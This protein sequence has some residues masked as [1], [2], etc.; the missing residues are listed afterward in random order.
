MSKIYRRP[1]FRGGGKVSSYG[2]GITAPLVPGYQ[3]GGQIGGGQIYGTPMGDGRYGFAQPVTLSEKLKAD[4]LTNGV[5][6]STENL[7]LGSDLLNNNRF[8]KT[9]APQKVNIEEDISTSTDNDASSKNIDG[10]EGETYTESIAKEQDKIFG[11]GNF[12]SFDQTEER[13]IIDENGNK[14][15]VQANV[16]AS[17]VEPNLDVLKNLPLWAGGIT[18]E[19]YKIRKNK[20]EI[21]KIQKRV[22]ADQ[23]NIARAGGAD[24]AQDDF[25]A[26]FASKEIGDGVGDKS[27]VVN[28]PEETQISAKDAIRENQELFKE[29]LGGKAARGQDISDMLLR[30]SGSQG[31]TLGEKFKNYTKAES[32]AG[33][34]RG[35]KINQTAAALAINDY[36]AGKRSDEQ[37]EYLTKKI[38]YEYKKKGELSTLNIDDDIGTAL[39]KSAKLTDSSFKSLKNIKNIINKKT[40]RDDIY[41]GNIK[42]KD[43][44]PKSFKQ[45]KVNKLKPGY[46]IVEDE[47]VKRIVLIGN[48]GTNNTVI[49]IQTI[50]ELWTGK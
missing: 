36:V 17:E 19:E 50:T 37:S 44:D 43:L 14:K 9:V 2:N 18:K 38:D 48:D 29:L 7:V 28:Q 10:G 25:D 34:G 33:P 26:G 15:I 49:S 47:G 13:T 24:A 21:K 23:N 42:I 3:G 16:P 12:G 35:E 32:A 11:D 46:N 20:Q 22:D 1:M 27:L 6:M 39:A 30:F 45:K 5:G 40:G 4:G 8:I 41:E 31:N